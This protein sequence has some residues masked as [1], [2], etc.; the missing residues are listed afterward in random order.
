MLSDTNLSEVVDIINMISLLVCSFVATF[1]RDV[2]A[3]GIMGFNSRWQMII[4]FRLPMRDCIT[5]KFFGDDLIKITIGLAATIIKYV[6]LKR[7]DYFSTRVHCLY[8][9]PISQPPFLDRMLP[10]TV[11]FLPFFC[12]YSLL[13][14]SFL[15]PLPMISFWIKLV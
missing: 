3:R 7:G 8:G 14:L 13:N 5:V 11:L 1:E 10:L 12:F 15:I 2:L 6:C 4:A 9:S